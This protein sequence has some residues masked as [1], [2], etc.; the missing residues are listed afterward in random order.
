MTPQ[1]FEEK[2]ELLNFPKEVKVVA[3]NEIERLKN[4]PPH[5]VEYSNN[6]KYLDW[7]YALPWSTSSED[8][9][10]ISEARTIL[11]KDHFNLENVKKRILEYIAV[12]KLNPTKKGPILCFYGPPGVGKTS[13][14]RS[15]AQALYRNFIRISLAGVHDESA[16]RGHSRTYV[17]S[18]PGRIINALKQ[19]KTN[20]PVILLDELDKVKGNAESSL[21]EVLDPEQ[22]HNFTDHYLQIPFDLSNII[23]IA[24]VN[25]LDTIS[26]AL[27]DRFEI[28]KL[29]GYKPNEASEIA[30]KFLIPKQIKEHGL[31][32]SNISIKF[33][34]ESILEIINGYT[35]DLGVR[36]LEKEICSI[37]RAVAVNIVEKGNESETLEIFINK[38]NI[39]EYLGPRRFNE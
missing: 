14:G 17:G 23:F 9:F 6:K 5:S 29:N 22:N 20:N 35:N 1:E 10:D 16:I 24:T 21:L 39:S 7:I 27:K 30:K 13:I 18:L 36:N 2:L 19:V 25:S 11:N 37:L 32:L 8:R 15:I 34:D 33:S 26:Y 12:R 3:K 4:Y 28:L 38:N 31:D